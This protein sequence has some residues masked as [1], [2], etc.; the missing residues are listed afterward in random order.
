MSDHGST[1]DPTPL[2]S[3]RDLSVSFPSEAGRVDA[4]RGVSFDLMPGRTLGI[5]GESGSGKSVTSLAVMGLLSSNAR[6]SGSVRLDGRELVGLSDKAMT[7]IRGKEIAMIFQDPLSSLTPVFPVGRQI[8]EAIQIHHDVSQKDATTRAVDLLGL[9][10]IPRPE[11]RIRSFPHEFSGGMRQRVMIAMAMANDPRLII[12]DEPTT[13]LDVTI[14]AQI[15]EV[16]ATAQRETGAAVIMVTHDL[17]V[18]AGNADD[19]VVMYAGRAVE[20]ADVNNIFY[21]PRMP[22]TIGLLEA[23]PRID[24][25]SEA[26]LVPITGNPP[27]LIDLPPGCPFAPRCPVVIDACRT[28]EPALL[29]VA[30]GATPHAPG[31]EGHL[32][33]RAACLRSD[34]IIHGTIGGQPV[35]AVPELPESTLARVPREERPVMLAVNGLHREFPL[36]RGSFLKRRVGTVYAVNGVSFDIRQGETMAIVGESGCGKTTTLLEIMNLAAPEGGN[37]MIGDV[38]TSSIKGASQARAVRRDLQMVFQ[39]PIGALDPRLTVYDIIAEPMQAVRMPRSR[40]E[41]RVSELMD[42][43]GLDPS[44][45]DRFPAA[46]SGGQRQRIGIARA[47]STN[48]KVVVLDEPVSAL[49]VSI[50]AGVINLLDELKVRLGLSYLFVAHD[51]SVVR[52]LADRVAVMYLG[53]FVEHGDVDAVFD[54]PQHPYTEALIS[55]IPLPDPVKERS[56]ERILL[57]GDLPS[58][59]DNSPGC[60]FVSRCPLH[61]T[62]AP[63]QQT[64]CR[65]STPELLGTP[66]H[67][68]ACHFR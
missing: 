65:E 27:L 10:G 37:L 43:V 40:I 18:V 16:L 34:E 50:Q 66:E 61:L 20:Q 1:A 2:L 14:Q 25:T 7:K 29:P 68:N 12:A 46:F 6:V 13:A 15:L 3:V 36:L 4:V 11:S 52:H 44:H 30:D 59:T 45:S 54:N 48:P 24:S 57:S 41:D 42:L 26:P 62:L 64:R 53:T 60:R 31:A 21:A 39:D 55:A 19:V 67:A 49:D 33:H 51:L 9:V 22:Y 32:P 23:I 17:G 47:L 35:Y 58:P 38:S 5:V 28:E 63:D 8:V 56:R